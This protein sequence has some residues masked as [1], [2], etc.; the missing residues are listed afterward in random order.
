VLPTCPKKLLPVNPFHQAGGTISFHDYDKVAVADKDG[1]VFMHGHVQDS[2]YKMCIEVI[3]QQQLSTQNEFNNISHS[4]DTAKT[5]VDGPSQTFFGL[6]FSGKISASSNDFAER[7]LEAHCALGHM[8]FDTVRQLFGLKKKG[9]NP[10]CAACAMNHRKSTLK[11]HKYERST[12]CNHRIHADIAFAGDFMFQVYIDDCSRVGYLDILKQKSEVFSKWVEL[13][14]FLDN[15][16]APYK[17][18]YFR[19]DNEFVYT[20]D[21]WIAHCKAEGVEHEFCPRYRHELNGVAERAILTIGISFRAMM[22]QG[23]A[24]DADIP[25]ALLHANV[26]RNNAPTS[27]NKGWTPKE[28]EA[29][30]RLGINRRLLSAPLFCLCYA[31]IYAEERG[32]HDPR[33]VACVY[34]GYDD[35]NNQYKV[36]EWISGKIYYTGDCTFHPKIYPYRANPQFTEQWMNET[37]AVTPRVPVSQ[38][39]PA[40]HS[41][42]TGPRRSARMHEYQTSGG[43]RLSDIPDH[44]VP[45]EPVRAANQNYYVHS[46]GPDPD[47]WE[48]AMSSPYAAEWTKAMLEEKN[49]FIHHNVYTL[50]PRAEAKGKKIYKPR[51]VFK[52]KVNP[53]APGSVTPTLDKFKYR[54]TI[55]AYSNTMKQGIDFE[56]KRASTVR[57][58]S[59]LVLIA[60]AV[61]YDLDIA[62]IDIKTFFLYGVLPDVVFMEQPPEWVD[63]EFPAKDYI[64]LLNRSMYG[65]PQAPHCAQ[66][67][68]LKTFVEGK[69]RQ[70]IADDCVFARKTPRES[71]FAASGSH[72]DDCLSVGSTAG[73][74]HLI[75]TLEGQFEVVVERNPTHITGVQIVR[76]R[77]AKWLKLHQGAFIMSIL[78]AFSMSDCTP[79]DTPMDPGTAKVL[80]SLDLATP[81]TVDPAVQQ[82]YRKLVGMLIWLYRT[83]IDV[84]FA[85]NLAAR[86][87]HLPTQK[88]FDLVK[89]RILRYLRGTIYL[90]LVFYY[91]DEQASPWILSGQSDSAFADDLKSSRSTRGHFLRMGGTGAVSA[92]CTLERKISTSTQQAETYALAALCRDCEYLR[93]LLAD[94]GCPQAA[95][96]PL[97]TDNDGTFKQ[98]TKQVNHATAKHFRVSQAYIRGLGNEGV[99]RVEKVGTAHNASDIFTKALP[100][101]LFLR[102]RSTIMGPQRPPNRSR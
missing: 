7:L 34:L 66:Q 28:K 9:G 37:D 1:T 25:N 88:H 44:D 54:L 42:P 67:K 40:P 85:V 101:S 96:S 27:A 14:R 3:T 62:A 53:P 60:L 69:Y 83:R 97:D 46:F 21:D 74:D 48:E 31:L 82:Q 11:Y 17:L 99:V 76:D 75:S 86:F 32:K 79:V 68:L 94:L 43:V 24:P 50:V 18:A 41:M 22:I 4:F 73:L 56:E 33:G 72:V 47:T 52:I 58:E 93:L 87:L 71:H 45:P 90:G 51:P 23:G 20:S 55:A 13:K 2:M 89:N 102:H 35:R 5:P 59:T 29:G 91:G 12:H 81:E 6:P 70:S 36:K 16:H 80:M 8:N 38:D 98:S 64:C 49:S 61:Q 39:N 15:K 30:M 92:N 26:I 57:W 78:A 77:K 10:H 84:L 100:A 95:P 63:P 65:L 19:T